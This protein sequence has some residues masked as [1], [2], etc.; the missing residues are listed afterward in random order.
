MV[1]LEEH[2]P[3]GAT[4]LSKGGVTLRWRSPFLVILGPCNCF[5][6]ATLSASYRLNLDGP[7]FL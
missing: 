1:G 4:T 5:S 6:S 3:P 2:F 7:A